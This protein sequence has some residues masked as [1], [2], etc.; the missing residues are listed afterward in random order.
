MAYTLQDVIAG[1]VLAALLMVFI[2]P[3]LDWVDEFQLKH[4]YAP[5]VMIV[6]TVAAALMYPQID[7]W[8]TCRGDTTLILGILLLYNICDCIMSY[9]STSA[10]YYYAMHW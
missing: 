6:V 9:H 7:E 1:L 8:S 2:I 5:L 10:V 4:P 3:A